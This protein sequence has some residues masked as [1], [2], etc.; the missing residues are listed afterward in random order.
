MKQKETFANLFYEVFITQIS[1]AG[2]Q[3]TKNLDAKIPNIL[4]N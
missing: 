1:K 2:K 3:S 4:R